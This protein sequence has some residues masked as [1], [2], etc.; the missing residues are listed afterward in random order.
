M[1]YHHSS[2]AFIAVSNVE[3]MAFGYLENSPASSLGPEA[4]PQAPF[5]GYEPWYNAPPANSM[6]STSEVPTMTDSLDRYM[7]SSDGNDIR[8]T[9]KIESSSASDTSSVDKKQYIRPWCSSSPTTQEVTPRERAK[10]VSLLSPFLLS[11]FPFSR[12]HP[13]VAL[14]QK[15]RLQNR[16]AQQKYRERKD[17]TIRDNQALIQR[18]ML[19]LERERQKVL[20]LEEKLKKIRPLADGGGWRS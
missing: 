15:R 9:L 2:S 20:S 10:S 5:W 8:S 16:L 3:A 14:T 7:A 18:L 12:I 13:H 11:A 1:T 19:A 6:G 17:A 4:A